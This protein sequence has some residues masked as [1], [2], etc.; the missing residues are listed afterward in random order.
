MLKVFWRVHFM[1]PQRLG[2]SAIF[3]L[4][5]VGFPFQVPSPLLFSPR[6]AELFVF[7]F[8][9]FYFS[10]FFIWAQREEVEEDEEEEKKKGNAVPCSGF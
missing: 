7:L 1:F 3:F 6:L 4:A 5:S 9:F 8:L 10:F 2:N